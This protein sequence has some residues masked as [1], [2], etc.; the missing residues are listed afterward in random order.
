MPADEQTERQHH[1]DNQARM[2]E[3]ERQQAE[4]KA[5]IAQLVEGLA[6]LGID[7]HTMKGNLAANT[8][9]SREAAEGIEAIKQQLGQLAQLDIPS[10]K[11]IAEYMNSMRGGVR[12]LGWLERPARWV[13]AIAGAVGALYGILKLKG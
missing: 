2:E 7:V 9:F 8:S 4:M 1:A 12:V 11:D 3:L 10:L 13:I 5:S 6:K